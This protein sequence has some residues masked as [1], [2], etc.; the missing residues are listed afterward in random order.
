MKISNELDATMYRCAFEDATKY[1]SQL[2]QAGE[3]V[4]VEDVHKAILQVYDKLRRSYLQFQMDKVG[5]V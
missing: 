5:G 3:Q 1:A 2:A 4:D